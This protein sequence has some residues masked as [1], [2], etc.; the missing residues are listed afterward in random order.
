MFMMVNIFKYICDYVFIEHRGYPVKTIILFPE[1]FN[2]VRSDRFFRENITHVRV[3]GMC[4][5]AS[6]DMIITVKD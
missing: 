1:E 5:D 2:L 4:S 6:N 3:T